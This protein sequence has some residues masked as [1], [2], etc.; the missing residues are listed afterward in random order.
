MSKEIAK[1]LNSTSLPKA[2]Y[3][4]EATI[5]NKNLNNFYYELTI[6]LNKNR[7]HKGYAKQ[8]NHLIIQNLCTN[9]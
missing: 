2:R 8:A 4:K 7:T 9:L 3:P 5:H 6:I 1:Y